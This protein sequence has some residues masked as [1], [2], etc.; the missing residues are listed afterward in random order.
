[1]MS[2]FLMVYIMVLN[3][4][5]IPTMILNFGGT[6]AARHFFSHFSDCVRV[7]QRGEISGP[8]GPFDMSL[9][10]TQR[11]RTHIS[12]LD[13]RRSKIWDTQ[14]KQVTSVSEKVFVSGLSVSKFFWRN[15]QE[16]LSNAR[17]WCS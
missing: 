5:Q 9:L 16:E 2:F 13:W 10:I 8:L 7:L 6:N 4:Y 17:N 15:C 14:E 1:M 12:N 3:Y 11:A